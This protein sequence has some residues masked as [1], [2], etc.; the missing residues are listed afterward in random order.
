MECQSCHTLLKPGAKF[1]P[2]CGAPVKARSA[3]AP[4]APSTVP[5]APTHRPVPPASGKTAQRVFMDFNQ[6]PA[7]I[8]QV[9][10]QALQQGESYQVQRKRQRRWLW[11]LFPAGLPFVCADVVLGYNFLTFSL[12]AITL[13][14]GA[15]FGLIWQ[16]RQGQGP[17]F[18]PRF[19]LAQTLF[20]T[21]KD[22]LAPKQT[23][24]GW[25]DLTGP[26]QE[27]KT[28]RQKNSQ[29]GQ[30]IMYYRDEW[31][32]LK[33]KLYDG[34]VLRLSMI[35]RVKARQG[36]YKRSRISGKNKWRAGSSQSQYELQFSLSINPGVYELLPIQPNT[37]IPNSRFVL[38]QGEARD[39][40][41]T[42]DAATNS[43]FDAWDILHVMRFGYQHLEKM[44]THL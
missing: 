31:L 26:E 25:L 18:G 38:L 32:R 35:D 33:T 24:V 23:L 27:G 5:T 20:E 43:E 29:S 3:P 1:C 34:N 19:G 41:I 42:L 40:R 8:A 2:A 6:P 44:D 9:M 21:I 14:L 15:V 10:K 28:I 7:D 30:P 17:Q 13:W 22:D 37:A 4:N 12:V 11:L 36:F 16:R 39:G